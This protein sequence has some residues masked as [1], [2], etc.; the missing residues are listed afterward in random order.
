MPD[1]GAEHVVRALEALGCR[2]GFLPGERGLDGVSAEYAGMALIML[3]NEA[4][5]VERAIFRGAHELGHLVLHP[6]LFDPATEEGTKTPPVAP[7]QAAAAQAKEPKQYEDEANHFAGCF[8]VPASE[9]LGLWHGE[10]LHRLPLLY[11]LLLLKRHFRVSF[12]AL[13]RRVVR[14]GLASTP[15]P[16][17]VDQLKR[18][19]DI[20][21]RAHMEDLEPD[22]MPATSLDRDTRLSRLVCGAFLN[23]EISVAK[24][25]DL[26]QIDVEAARDLAHEW[27]KPRTTMVG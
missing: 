21:G 26:L 2:V 11:A 22:P 14:L 24:V 13:Y 15:Y 9:L 8:L 16:Q 3:P 27:Q 17:M 1:L 25:A 7:G 18:H 20:Q 19:L 23:G 4:P 10:R 5:I 12:W 6:E